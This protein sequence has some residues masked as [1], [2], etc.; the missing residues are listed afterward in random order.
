MGSDW[1]YFWCVGGD[2]GCEMSK[3]NEWDLI[4]WLHK[5]NY[6][7]GKWQIKIRDNGNEFTGPRLQIHIVSPQMPNGKY[8]SLSTEEYFDSETKYRHR[9]SSEDT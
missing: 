8:M 4:T 2:E 6:V 9:D 7:A 3:F 5:Q 1:C